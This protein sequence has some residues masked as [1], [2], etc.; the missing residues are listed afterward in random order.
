[1]VE[2]VNVKAR[3]VKLKESLSWFIKNREIS[4][5]EDITNSSYMYQVWQNQINERFEALERINLIEKTLLPTTI[6]YLKE[7]YEQEHKYQFLLLCKPPLYNDQ[8]IYTRN[9]ELKR[10]KLFNKLKKYM[11]Q[12]SES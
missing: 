6:G 5:D 3:E 10:Q 7:K 4:D 2:D 9:M 11:Q 8:V 12:N 1:M